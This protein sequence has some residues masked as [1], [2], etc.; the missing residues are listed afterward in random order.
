MAKEMAGLNTANC[1]K[2]YPGHHKFGKEYQYAPLRMIFDVKKEDFRRK[3]RLVAGGH[4]IN[5]SMFESYSSVVQ[6]NS[7]RLLQTVALNEDFKIITADI[8]NAFIQ[9]FTKEKIGQDVAMNSG[10]SPDVSLK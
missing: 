3:A 4:V 6:T 8:G 9:A 10:R 2:Y 1:F 7:L 5:S